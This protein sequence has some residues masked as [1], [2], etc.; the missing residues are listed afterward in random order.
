MEKIQERKAPDM[1]QHELPQI[2]REE[3][4]VRAAILQV[5][6]REYLPLAESESRF[7]ATLRE[8]RQ[9]RE[10]S[11]RK[12]AEDKIKWAENQTK[13]D[14]NQAELREMR[15]E[16]ERKWA[17]DKNRWEQNQAE[18]RVVREESERKWAENQTKWDQNQAELRVMREESERKWAENQTELRQMREE[19]ERKWAEDKTRWDQNQAELR[20]MR[21][22]SERKWQEGQLSLER[23]IVGVN[24]RIDSSLGAVGSRWG[25]AAES[26]FRDAMAAILADFSNLQV[27]HVNEKDEQGEVFG[28]PDQVELDLIIR[29]GILIIAE[30]KS[31]MS[32]SD[33]YI[34]ERKV[35]FYERKHGRTAARRMVISPMV[36][37]KARALAKEFGIEVYSYCEDVKV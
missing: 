22:E 15:E 9:M 1:F 14:Q 8:L 6:S 16:S 36:D 5:T 37:E 27:M 26:S 24:R 32:R 17:E 23:A 21:E 12:W 34:F 7:D 19:S 30:I 29:D 18:L 10:E 4:Q 13:W 2:L 33:M 31:S 25:I 11:E 28:R 35:R 20:Q 3:A